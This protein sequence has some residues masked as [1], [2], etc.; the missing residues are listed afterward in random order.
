M[1]SSYGSQGSAAIQ[2]QQMMNAYLKDKQN[3][4]TIGYKP[5]NVQFQDYYNQAYSGGM[6]ARNMSTSIVFT[7]GQIVESPNKN[8]LDLAI[9]GNGL[10]SLSDGK[11]MVYTRDGQLSWEPSTGTLVHKSTG[12]KVMGKMLDANQN[13][14]GELCEFKTDGANSYR[15]DETG[16]L[17]KTEII[18]DSKGTGQT[19][20]R[21][22]PVFQVSIA[23][24]LNPSGLKRFGNNAFVPSNN[25]GK[26][27]QGF[28]GMGSSFGIVHPSSVELSSFD[29]S[30][31]S[32]QLV[33][34]QQEH[35][36]NINALKLM[37]KMTQNAMNLIK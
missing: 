25:S 7:Q 8:P 10:F 22:V 36:A 2:N 19:Q 3:W 12:M 28:S 15:F 23:S 16:K 27:V 6:G 31:N 1:Y 37:D 29:I 11:K 17:Y 30:Q 13:P 33:K 24:F 21:E 26:P 18:Q 34:A 9:E 32:Q 5:D 4:S 14:T 20:T 35:D